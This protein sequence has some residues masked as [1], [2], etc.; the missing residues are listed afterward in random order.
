MMTKR[1]Y[2]SYQLRE[3]KP[4]RIFIRNLHSSTPTKPIKEESKFRLSEARQVTNIKSGV[5]Y[6]PQANQ[7]RGSPTRDGR[8]TMA[9]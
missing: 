1:K 5:P 3:D 9:S 6:S 8:R 4:L 2:H 7:I